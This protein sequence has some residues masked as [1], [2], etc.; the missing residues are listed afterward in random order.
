MSKTDSEFEKQI[1]DQTAHLF[2]GVGTGGILP[3]ASWAFGVVGLC[4][5][6]ALSLGSLYAWIMRE[7]AQRE[8]KLQRDGTYRGAGSH[9]PWDPWLDSAVFL[10]GIALG[11]A[12][13]YF[14]LIRG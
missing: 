7:G 8:G 9:V 11:G 6:A 1:K 3:V 4:S 13:G 14:L 12:L 2:W 5:A 10:A